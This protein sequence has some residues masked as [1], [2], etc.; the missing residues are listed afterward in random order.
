MET[1]NQNSREVIISNNKENLQ[2]NPKIFV[3]YILAFV[4]GLTLGALTALLLAPTSGEELRG[5]IQVK[6]GASGQQ[7]KAN[8]DQARQWVTDETGKLRKDKQT[9]E[10]AEVQ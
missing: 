8:Y 9:E 3:G 1:A 10:E 4:S 2:M 5:Q 6:A 7:I